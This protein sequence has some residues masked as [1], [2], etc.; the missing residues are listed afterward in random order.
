MKIEQI[1]EILESHGTVKSLLHR[2]LKQLQRQAG[3]APARE[4]P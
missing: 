3:S 4:E 2:A 1:A